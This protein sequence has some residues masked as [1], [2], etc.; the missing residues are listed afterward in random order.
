M[1]RNTPPKRNQ[2]RQQLAYLAARLMA[3][4][5]VQ[6][7]ALAKLKA[8]RQMGVP[9]T[10]QLP[11]N[12]EVE[13][14][15]RAFQALYQQDRHDDDLRRLRV[16]AVEV[17]QLLES[18][19]PYLTGSVLAGTAGRFSDINLQLFCDSL[20]DVEWFLLSRNIPYQTGS[21]RVQLGDRPI[22]IGLITLDYQGTQISVAV[23]GTDDI[24]VAQKRRANGSLVERAS[25]AE[26]KALL[27]PADAHLDESAASH[28]AAVRAK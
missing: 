14:A 20:K 22:D 10:Q 21:K 15:L 25:L 6:N 13:E 28:S 19:Q 12:K 1:G 23:Y 2:M 4:G 26:A 27:S 9:D 8:A 17:M 18:F 3:E 11:D 24:R 16:L 5:G 7:Y